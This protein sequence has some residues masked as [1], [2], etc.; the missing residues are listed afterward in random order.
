M[1]NHCRHLIDLDTVDGK[2]KLKPGHRKLI[3]AL[4]KKAAAYL[5]N[6]S[7]KIEEQKETANQVAFE[8]IELLSEEEIDE[9]NNV[10]IDKL[11][12]CLT[13][14]NITSIKYTQNEIGKSKH[15]LAI[16]A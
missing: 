14:C 3:I 12:K 2:F 16:P 4:S 1:E 10:L 15:I 7:R 13:S 6:K 9:L 5:E 8:E 11:N